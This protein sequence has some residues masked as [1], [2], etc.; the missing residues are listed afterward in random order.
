MKCDNYHTNP[1]LVTQVEYPKVTFKLSL[2][3]SSNNMK[4]KYVVRNTLYIL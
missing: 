3:K 1:I 2:V 4:Y